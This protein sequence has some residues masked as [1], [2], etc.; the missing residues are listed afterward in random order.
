MD[1]NTI[2]VGVIAVL[3]G[4]IGGFLLATK[5]DRSEI[6]RLR[7]QTA[8]QTQPSSN[9]TKPDDQTLSPQE[10]KAKIDEADK[11][12]DNFS[13]QKNLGIALYRYGAMKQDENVISEAVRILT[14]ATTLDQKD[15]DVL[16]SLGNA[17]FDL[18]F[19]KK[20]PNGFQKSR[21][22]YA[23]ALA[24]RED[25]DVRTDLGISYLVADQPDL[26]KAAAELERVASANPRHDRSMQFLVQV[27]IKQNRLVD[28][29][30]ALAK[31]KEISPGNPAIGDLTTQLN[32]ARSGKTS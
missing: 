15:F 32:T 28:A 25:A 27:Y 10:I 3:S 26:A 8:S 21:E 13:F 7:A 29:D 19:A 17:E 18:G 11:N 14:R 16:V 5:L 30:K 31:I 12:P 4:F 24:I 1:K 6:D 23:K 20:D 2:L 9:S 22:D